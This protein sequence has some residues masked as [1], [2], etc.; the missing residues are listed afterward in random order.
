[1]EEKYPYFQEK[2]CTNFPGS[3]NLM[4]FVV[5]GNSCISHIMKYTIGCESNG[6]KAPILWENCRSIFPVS[7]HMMGL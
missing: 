2:N 7:P 3:P 4:N 5:M 1:M 6:R